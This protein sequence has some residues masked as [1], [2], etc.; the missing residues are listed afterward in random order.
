MLACWCCRNCLYIGQVSTS[1]TNFIFLDARASCTAV[2]FGIALAHIAKCACAVTT[3]NVLIVS[4]LVS[5]HLQLS[6]SA[7]GCLQTLSG[8]WAVASLSQ[9]EEELCCHPLLFQ[10]KSNGTILEDIWENKGNFDGCGKRWQI[11]SPAWV[12][13]I[14]KE[15]HLYTYTRYICRSDSRSDL[16]LMEKQS[17]N[18]KTLLLA[19]PHSCS[20]Q[21]NE[22]VVGGG[23]VSTVVAS[24][25]SNPSF[26]ILDSLHPFT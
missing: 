15:S 14:I 9:I 22:T 13:S 21:S 3:E 16:G 24:Q 5:V 18:W 19:V 8:H 4:E 12:N 11:T 17:E 7:A 26:T 20:G 10:L 25:L 6:L 2:N 23:G 1:Y